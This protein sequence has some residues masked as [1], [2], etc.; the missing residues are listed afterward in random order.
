MADGSFLVEGSAWY[1]LSDHVPFGQDQFCTNKHAHY[2]KLFNAFQSGM[3]NVIL[4]HTYFI[5]YTFL[6]QHIYIQL[7]HLCNQSS[8]YSFSFSFKTSLPDIES[9]QQAWY[10]SY[11]YPLQYES[12]LTIARTVGSMIVSFSLH[13]TSSVSPFM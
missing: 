4:Q 8:W 13:S 12:Q 11:D 10:Y 5:P 6:F 7:I 2:C 1:S 3:L 9:Y